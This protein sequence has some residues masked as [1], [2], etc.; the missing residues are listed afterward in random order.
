[1]ASAG[2]KKG[3]EIHF[4]NVERKRRNKEK[5]QCILTTSVLIKVIFILKQWR[6]MFVTFSLSLL[7]R[8]WWTGSQ[9]MLC[10]STITRGC[11]RKCKKSQ[12]AAEIIVS[13]NSRDT[14][15]VSRSGGVYLQEQRS[16]SACCRLVLS[17]LTPHKGEL[18]FSFTPRRPSPRSHCCLALLQF[19]WQAA[20][21][22]LLVCPARAFSALTLQ[23][24]FSFLFQALI[25]AFSLFHTEGKNV[26][27]HSGQRF[28]LPKC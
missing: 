5:F 3:I 19:C 12:E 1:M 17:Q 16:S 15:C 9:L 23:L 4:K 2:L 24:S 18:N 25:D 8:C 21:K 7:L 22:P 10:V 28:S 26:L 6:N 14:A 11:S 20:A 27:P 13:L